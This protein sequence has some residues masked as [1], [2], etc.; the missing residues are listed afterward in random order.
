MRHLVGLVL[1]PH[2]VKHFAD[3]P[4]GLVPVLPSCRLQ[5][6]LQIAFHA[7]VHQQLEVLEHHPDPAPEEG[8]VL[9]LEFVE[10][11]PADLSGSAGQRILTDH[12]ADDGCLAGS[13]L[14]DDVDEVRR[15]YLHVESV[16]HG[17]FP[18]EDVRALE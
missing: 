5:H 4:V 3:P 8:D 9:V 7:P 17:A 1:H 15:E 10:P 11:E 13:D 6:E 12:R 14:P 18:V 16:D 2:V